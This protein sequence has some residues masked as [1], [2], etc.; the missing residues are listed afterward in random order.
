MIKD[1]SIR[2]RDATV[3][4]LAPAAASL[5]ELRLIFR[6]VKVRER[7]TRFSRVRNPNCVRNSATIRKPTYTSHPFLLIR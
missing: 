2:Q 4:S 6:W 5:E 1:Y 7:V 3:G